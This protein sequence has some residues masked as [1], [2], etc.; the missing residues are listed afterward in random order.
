MTVGFGLRIVILKW[1]H[2]SDVDICALVF[3]DSSIGERA[4]TITRDAE[5][6]KLNERMA[7]QRQLKFII[8]E[9][10]CD[11]VTCCQMIFWNGT[12]K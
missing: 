5:P 3:D 12:L 9:V 11:F 2:Q 4:T 10:F 1:S 7:F 6:M 8:A